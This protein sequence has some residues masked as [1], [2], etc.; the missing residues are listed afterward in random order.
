M[1]FKNK[2]AK[3]VNQQP[4]IFCGWNA[5][6]RHAAHIID[7]IECEWNAISLCPNCHTVFDEILRPKL[8][9]ALE[10]IGAE[11]LPDSWK[12]NNKLRKEKLIS[13]VDVSVL[14]EDLK[15]LGRT[16]QNKK[17]EKN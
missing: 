6:S 15:E 12:I 9:L 17:K 7:E 16:L 4:C 1:A 11:N 8:Y 13:R 14:P 5:G 2:K 3:S 10:K